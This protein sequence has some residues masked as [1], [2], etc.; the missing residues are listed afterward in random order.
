LNGARNTELHE[1]VERLQ[2][3]VSQIRRVSLSMK[4]RAQPTIESLQRIVNAVLVSDPVEARLAC[5]EHVRSAAAATLPVL[6]ITNGIA[7]SGPKDYRSP[8]V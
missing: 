3:R 5:I 4:E 7:G 6:A 1:V 2:V 8:F